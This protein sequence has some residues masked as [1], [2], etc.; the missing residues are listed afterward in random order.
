VAGFRV[1]VKVTGAE[2]VVRRLNLMADKAEEAVEAAAM[3]GAEV[4]R[5]DAQKRAPRGD[6][7][8]LAEGMTAELEG[9]KGTKATVRIGPDKE[10]FYGLFHEVGT[11]KMPARPFLRPALD[12]RK[13]EAEKAVADELRR[14]LGL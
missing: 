10:A 3:A 9:V 8:R 6:T 12:E 4:V 7:E 5:A 1:R 13:A 2:E 11:K 14:K